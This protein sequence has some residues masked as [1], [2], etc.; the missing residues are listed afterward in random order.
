LAGAFAGLAFP[1]CARAAPSSLAFTVLRNGKPIGR[2]RM[3]FKADGGALVVN[4][5]A[6]MA[7]KAGPLTLYHYR[8]EA[9]ERWSGGRFDSLETRTDSNGKPLK[10][11]ARRTDGGVVIV[12]ASGERVNAPASALPMTH[13]NR[14]IG[15]A[16]LFNP[17]DGK[18]LREAVT[19]TPTRLAFSGDAEIQDFYD[20][21]G[22]WIGLIGK[23]S[24]GSRLEYR[25]I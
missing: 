15:S 10:I 24:D 5:V 25:P 22:T 7:V 11:S 4:T 6:E 3:A 8:H 19:A 16:P 17:Q 12:R 1:M 23:L 18:L 2:Q 9:E 13:W 21:A 20:L 14:K